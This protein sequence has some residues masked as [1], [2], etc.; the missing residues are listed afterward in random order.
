[1]V[2]EWIIVDQVDLLIQSLIVLVQDIKSL[3]Y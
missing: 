3:L 2:V 1:M